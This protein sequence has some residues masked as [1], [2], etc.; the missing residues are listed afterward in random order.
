MDEPI[1]KMGH[2]GK[3]S[4]SGKYLDLGMIDTRE[5]VVSIQTNVV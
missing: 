1:E 5:P 3:L 4:H 2:V